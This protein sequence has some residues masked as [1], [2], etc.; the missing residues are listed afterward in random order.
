MPW[1]TT[2]KTCVCEAICPRN[3][4]SDTRPEGELPLATRFEVGVPASI[5]AESIISALTH[6]M[7]L[8]QV[9]LERVEAP[10]GRCTELRFAMLNRMFAVV[11]VMGGAERYDL[12]AACDELARHVSAALARIPSFSDVRESA[13]S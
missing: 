12:T 9:S 6:G 4:S 7:T 2:S 5:P 10:Q 1:P 11:R 3:A 13:N 8:Q